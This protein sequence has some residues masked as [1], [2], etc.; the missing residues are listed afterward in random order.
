[1]DAENKGRIKGRVWIGPSLSY[2]FF[3][4]TPDGLLYRQDGFE[5]SQDASSAIN[6]LGTKLA[7]EGKGTWKTYI[8]NGK[9]H[10]T[11]RG[12]KASEDSYMSEAIFSGNSR[13]RLLPTM[14]PDVPGRIVEKRR[15]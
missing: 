8:F 11:K 9:T 13:T 7:S 5:T 2:S 14:L 12:P 4:K 10:Y 3:I 6:L 15:K 1:M